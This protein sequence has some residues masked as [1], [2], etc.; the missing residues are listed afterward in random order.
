MWLPGLIM[1][2]FPMVTDNG[3]ACKRFECGFRNRKGKGGEMIVSLSQF[4]PPFIHLP[5]IL[6]LPWVF[7]F[8]P[9]TS[10]KYLMFKG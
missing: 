6:M 4:T 8:H 10:T 5:Y 3:I 1:Q 9:I 7:S 2:L